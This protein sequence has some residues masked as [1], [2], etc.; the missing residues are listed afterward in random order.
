MYRILRVVILAVVFSSPLSAQKPFIFPVAGEPGPSTW[1]FGQP[2]GNTTG[3]FNFGTEWYSAG[4]GLHFGIDV[5]MPCNTPLVAVADG[6]VVFVDNLAF[7]SGPH[8][9]ILRHAEHG[10]TTLYGHLLGPAP[11]SVGQRV[12]QGDVV[13][14]SGDPDVTCDS[15]PHLHFEIRSNDFSTTY[16]PVN[17]IDMNWHSLAIVGSYGYPLF[18]GDMDNA[19]RWQTLEDQPTVSFGGARLNAYTA[20]YPVANN[21]RPPLNPRLAVDAPEISADWQI[22]TIGGDQ[23]CWIHWWH[24]TDPDRLYAIDGASNQRAAVFEWSASEGAMQFVSET[25]PPSHK[26]P[27]G[28]YEI[29]MEGSEA[30]IRSLTDET[31]YRVNTNGATPS[32]STDNSRLVWTNTAL[33]V[34]GAERPPSTV[35]IAPVDGTSIQEVISSPGA[36]AQWLDAA[37]LLV[38]LPGEARTVEY[39]VYDTRDM[40]SFSLGIWSW[41]R[42]LSIAPGGGRIM[43]YTTNQPNPDDSAIYTLETRPDA[44]A[45]KLTWFGGWRWRDANTVYYIP[46][47]TSTPLHTLHAYN[48]ET[49]EDLTLITPEE[50][51]FTIMNGNWSVSA[52]G[53]RILFNNGVDFELTLLEPSA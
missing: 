47:D 45:E 12:N 28:T 44:V 2:Y 39:R 27:D 25:A 9:L 40:S 31:I 34:P 35:Y 36:S 32:L 20:P 48:I 53:Q 29:V 6:E 7:G 38:S 19:R 22:R 52:D 37:R 17:Y 8:N 14:Y 16:N 15:R 21:L 46:Q 41:V 30:V 10:L 23:C 50:L 1:Q 4:Q 43:F 18:Q 11:V 5:G 26:S 3:A 33:A 49:G 51:P 13:A 24:P 42:N